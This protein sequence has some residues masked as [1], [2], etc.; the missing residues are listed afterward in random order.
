MEIFRLL[1]ESKLR[2]PRNVKLQR[3]YERMMS[4]LRTAL[5]EANAYTRQSMQ[6]TLD[7]RY[8]HVVSGVVY[9]PSSHVPDSGSELYDFIKRHST[10]YDVFLIDAAVNILN[11]EDLTKKYDVYKESLRDSLVIKLKSCEKKNISLPP[12]RQDHVSMVVAIDEDQA[13]LA[14]VMHLRDFF[15]EYIGLQDCLFEGF[16]EGC[17]IVYFA[18]TAVDALLVAPK[19]LSQL[20]DL[21]TMFSVTHV[22][23]FGHFAVDVKSGTCELLVS[24]VIVYLHMMF[25]TQYC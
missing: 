11:D 9:S 14:L 19:I 3:E 6:A 17:L 7:I 8:E 18:I 16:Q 15:V 1:R 25:S 5:T 22:V 20:E 10:V 13:L 23:V 12:L 24:L 2:L 21:K 4:L